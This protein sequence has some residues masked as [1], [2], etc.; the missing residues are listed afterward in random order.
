MWWPGPP[1][2][3][4]EEVGGWRMWW[5]GGQDPSRSSGRVVEEVVVT[6]L[7]PGGPS[8]LDS[9]GGRVVDVVAGS[10]WTLR[11]QIEK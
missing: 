11:A 6:W 5:P 7:G 1:R 10:R 4:R 3:Y 8:A 9:T 2:S